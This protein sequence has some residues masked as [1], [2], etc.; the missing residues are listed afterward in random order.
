MADTQES[1]R[2]GHLMRRFAT[3]SWLVAAVTLAA[4]GSSGSDGDTD[5]ANDDAAE[6]SDAV[7]GAQE[8]LEEVR[9]SD[10]SA[11]GIIS[12]QGVEYIF[13][14]GSCYT[15]ESFF[16]ASGPGTTADGVPFWA[17]VS[18][19]VETRLG[20][21]QAGLPEDGIDAL[22]GDKDSLQFFSL[23]VELG[24]EDAFGSGD[25]ALADFGQDVTDVA[26]S[27][28]V[29]LAVEGNTLSGSGQ[30]YD[31]NGVL[32]AFNETAAVNFTA[33]CP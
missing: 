13:D 19:G 32:I 1:N 20:M 22:F 33:T 2:R 5:A 3:A 10:V 8:D 9:E 12:I 14:S 23:A 7:A 6:A 25:D 29:S 21:E 17:S 26:E 30:A 4:C 31:S 15:D 18:F 24:K 16:E 28:L 11:T 27:D